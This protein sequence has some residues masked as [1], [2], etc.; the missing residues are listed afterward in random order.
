M[1]ES[2]RGGWGEDKRRVERTGEERR[3]EERKERR[4]KETTARRGE[5]RSGRRGEGKR[6]KE[7]KW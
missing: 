1:I 3:L 7:R 2:S 5:G 6:G 4:G